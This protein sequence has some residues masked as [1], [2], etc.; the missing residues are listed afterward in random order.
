[1][2]S[3]LAKESLAQRWRELLANPDA[4]DFCELDERG[5]I[6]VNPPPC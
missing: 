2:D 3:T 6:I 1:M 4:P 5:E